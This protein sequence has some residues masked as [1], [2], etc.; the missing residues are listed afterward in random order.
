VLAGAASADYRAPHPPAFYR[1][2]LDAQAR[3]VA[4]HGGIR[5]HRYGDATPAMKQLVR[6]LIRQRFRPAGWGAVTRALCFSR[7]ESGWNPAADSPSDDHG[8]FQVHRA[9]YHPFDW[10]RISRDPAYS[11][12]VGWVVSSYGRDWGPWANGSRPC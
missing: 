1:N 8:A 6:A 12:W 2:T 5:S 4:G 11:V 10:P 3:Y 9:S 7:R